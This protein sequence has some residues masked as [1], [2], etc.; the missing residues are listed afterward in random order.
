MNDL[1]CGDNIQ[2]LKGLDDN[3]ID[4]TVTSPPYDKLRQYNG[5][6]FDLDGIIKE[7]LRVT[8]PGG[9]VVWVVGDET[10][11]GNESGSSFEQ[12]LKFKELG[13]N[14]HDTMIFQKN[15]Y[16]PN[17]MSQKRYAQ[18]FEYMFVFSKGKVNTF[19]RIM[20]PNKTAGL[21]SG[22]PRTF[23][24]RNN[25]DKSYGTN[26]S[27]I[28]AKESVREAIWKYNVGKAS[29]DISYKH[30]AVF[31]ES[32]AHDHIISW[33]N[34]GDV[35]LDPFVGSGTTCKV[36]KQLNRNYIGI[37]ISQEYIDIAIQRLE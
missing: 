7:L 10:K 12:A 27:K 29:G 28:T 21:S 26:K 3:C 4:L 24:Q 16:P 32:L 17:C 25:I 35:V 30:P 14:L 23:P 9:V 33:S 34:E 15:Q 20:R 37:D 13:W 18:V 2:I 31:P 11:D 8:K 22:K 6:S 19:N 5:F 1:V 36:A